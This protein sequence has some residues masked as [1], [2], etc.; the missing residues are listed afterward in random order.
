MVSSTWTLTLKLLLPTFWFC[1][2]GGC[3]IALFFY[4]LEGIGEPFTPTSARLMMVSFLLSSAGVYYLVF[5]PI[6]WVAMD[7]NKLYVSNFMKSYQYT[8]ES[9]AKVEEHKMLLWNKV[10]IHFHETGYFG[11]SIVFFGSYYWHYYLKQHPEILQI[12]LEHQSTE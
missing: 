9:I 2:F 12:I 7:A 8:Y 4:P 11:K 3:T 10:T 1:F 5:Y 6:K